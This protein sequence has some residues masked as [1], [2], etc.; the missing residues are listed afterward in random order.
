ML[1]R[2]IQQ[3]PEHIYKFVRNAICKRIKYMRDNKRA[4][5]LFGRLTDLGA[6]FST[7][8]VVCSDMG[9]R[10]FLAMSSVNPFAISQCLYNVLH[11]K[12][13]EWIREHIKDDIRRNYVWT[14]E[15]LCFDG[16][17]FSHASK[18]LALLAVAENED[19]GNN[20]TGQ[21]KQLFHIHLAGTE[22]NLDQ[23]LELIKIG[24]A[25]V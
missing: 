8:K 23:R 6:P 14:L 4:Y 21:F 25:H 3:W 2:S 20:A 1:F 12:T 18:V 11:G 16:E 15:T 22:A 7:E 9:S 17:S 13:I 10:L 19:W 24:R 5:E